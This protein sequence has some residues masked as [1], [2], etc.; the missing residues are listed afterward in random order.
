VPTKCGKRLVIEFPCDME[1]KK[2]EERKSR[3]MSSF[4]S[5]M[6]RYTNRNSTKSMG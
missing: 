3:T 6:A 5:I 1:G 2:E 4:P